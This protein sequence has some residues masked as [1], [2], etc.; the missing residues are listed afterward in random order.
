[1][2]QTKVIYRLKKNCLRGMKEIS[3]KKNEDNPF[4]L[5]IMKPVCHQEKGLSNWVL[6]KL[7]FN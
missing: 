3:S 6:E 4:V 5:E 7:Y 1:M 2:F